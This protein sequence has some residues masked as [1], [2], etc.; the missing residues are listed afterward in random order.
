MRYIGSKTKMHEILKKEITS[1]T[2]CPDGSVFCDI[3]SGTCGVGDYMQDVYKIIAND[4][5]Y[6]SYIIARGKLNNIDYSFSK[7]GFD[8][9]NFFNNADTSNYIDGYCYKTFGPDI[10]GRQYFSSE[11]SKLIDFI[12]DYI[13]LWY[14]NEKI[15]IQEHDYLL[16]CLIESMSKVANVAGVYAAYLHM[17]DSRAI[18]KMEFIKVEHINIPKY[19]N[20][21]FNKDVNN[22]IEDI[23]G[24]ILY[25]DLH[26][27]FPNITC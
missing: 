25:L 1:F 12:R 7:L 2:K 16:A 23:S 21:V 24:H 4:S 19:N 26:N 20:E 11:N 3:F 15:T 13:E 6:F 8:P 27:M 18:K 9:F 5:L 10:T 17:W 14:S 22:V